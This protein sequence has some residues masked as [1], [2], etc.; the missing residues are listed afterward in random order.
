MR[1]TRSLVE[2]N[3][4]S[5]EAFESRFARAPE[6]RSR[7]P[8]RVNLIGEHTDYSGGLVLPCA[9]DRSLEV[10]AAARDDGQIHAWARDLAPPHDSV[11]FACGESASQ[12]GFG[13]YLRAVACALI[14]CG[15]PCPGA[16][17]AI[18]SE[19]PREAGL[20]S[21]AALCVAVCNA[22]LRV[23]GV[24]VS[25]ERLA[26]LAHRAESHFVGTQCGILDQTAVSFG[27]R[28]HALRIDC[29][30]GER[31]AIPLSEERFT[32]LI[33]DS[34]VARTLAQVAG[35]AVPAYRVRVAECHEA[36]EAARAAGIGGRD[37][38]SLRDFTASDLDALE[39]AIA[40]PLFRRVRHVVREN[41]R[42]DAVCDALLHA[43]GPDVARVGALLREG[44]ASLRDDFEAS[45]PEL[46]FLCASADALAGVFGSRLTGAGFGGCTI[47]LVEPTHAAAVA[48]SLADSFASEFGG[49]P[50]VIAV[51]AADGAEVEAI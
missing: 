46:D 45:T 37:A 15:L 24:E 32:I 18:A 19:L 36:Y 3:S 8:G 40:P 25:R 29:R 21:S 47:H 2:L 4:E 34:G 41:A 26:E 12:G 17:L 42:V 16:D 23:A 35:E 38:T 49:R 14:E 51:Q 5:L 27:Q 28:G 43:G 30:S 31:R 7:A 10:L 13:D 22:L 39:R 9:I 50:R 20:S 33:A 11:R 1:R 6:W 48:E 44:Q